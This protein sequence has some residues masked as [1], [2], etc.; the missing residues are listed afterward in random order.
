MAH[1][2]GDVVDGVEVAVGL[3]DAG[4]ARRLRAGADDA[5]PGDAAA[6]LAERDVG[7]VELVGADDLAGDGAVAVEG[8]AGTARDLIQRVTGVVA[9]GPVR[10]N[11]LAVGVE[12]EQVV[13]ADEDHR[14][15]LLGFVDLID[16]VHQRDLRRGDVGRAAEVLG[17]AGLADQGEAV[18]AQL[19]AV[20]EAAGRGRLALGDAGRARDRALGR[21]LAERA[22][23]I[24]EVGAVVAG[25]E[26]LV[27]VV[28]RVDVPTAEL[29]AADRGLEAERALRDP[30]RGGRVVDALAGVGLDLRVR[31][32]Q[33]RRH[34]PVR[35][36]LEALG[37][38]VGSGERDLAVSGRESPVGR[39]QLGGELGAVEREGRAR[40]RSRRRGR[41][42]RGSA[43]APS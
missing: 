17:V 10:G 3:G 8:A 18:R 9:A 42:R 36:D 5:E 39:R 13:V 16:P 41:C 4:A 22:V 23:A 30:D 1:L 24:G 12:V 32:G 37:A 14:D 20:A 34:H 31:G 7:D 6:R 26:A 40:S 25:V 28:G 19:R 21:Q 43:R 35:R 33:L 38:A 15:R 27:E 29:A 11:R 2:V